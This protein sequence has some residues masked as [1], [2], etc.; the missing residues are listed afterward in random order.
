MVDK[1]NEEGYRLAYVVIERR[2][3]YF[4]WGLCAMVM[5]VGGLILA[6]GDATYG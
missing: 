2:L 3:K 1:A 4:S 5:E 6:L